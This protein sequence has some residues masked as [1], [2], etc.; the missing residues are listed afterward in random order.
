MNAPL[1]R[2]DASAART[3]RVDIIDS[4]DV[5]TILIGQEWAVLRFN[6]AAA[7]LLS[8]TPASLRRPTSEI[9]LLKDVKRLEELCQEAIGSGISSQ[10][11]VRDPTNGSWYILRIAP[12]MGGEPRI[13]SAVLT[14]QNVTAFRAS[15]EQ[16]VYEREY[17][18]A[19]INTV[20]DSLVVLDD[21]CRVQAAN[22]AFYTKFQVS[23]DQAHGARL[24]DIGS[25]DWEVPRLK[26]LLKEIDVES[27]SD[28]EFEHEFP[29]I[30]RRTVMLNARRLPLKAAL[31]SQGG[32]VPEMTLLVIQDI[33]E[34]KQAELGFRKLSE[35]RC[36]SAR[37][38]SGT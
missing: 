11:E 27:Q 9:P 4:V 23:R 26:K 14:F 36:R 13:N 16:A 6:P 1:T 37:P 7:T 21:D 2:P 22:Q 19:I 32:N 15:L 17:T 24:Y 38:N 3:S 31:F 33:T 5:P 20:I 10:C 12:Y 34:R 8:L 18:K 35:A 30:G 25:Q 28:A 29:A